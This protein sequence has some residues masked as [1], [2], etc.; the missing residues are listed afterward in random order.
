MNILFLTNYFGLHGSSIDLLTYTK[1]LKKMG[2]KVF[3]VGGDGYLR[4]A[5]EEIADNIYVLQ[6]PK[7]L[8][9]IKRVLLLKQLINAWN[10]DV[11][12]GVG[13]FLILESQIASLIF[14][15]RQPVNIMN[16]SPRYYHWDIHPGWH[17][18]MVGY[19]A[20]NCRFYKDRTIS[21]YK[22]P[23]EYIRLLSARYDIPENIRKLPNISNRKKVLFVRRLDFPKYKS[24]LNTLDQISKWDIWK[25]WSIEIAGGGSHEGLVR[26]EIEKIRSI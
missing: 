3:F 13:K 15:K 19:L 12:I 8:P 4:S 1:Y 16:F 26:D 22:W 11:I 17:L 2:H 5:F 6:N 9:S 23:E 7:Y 10:I 20:V 25:E 24:V 21:E 18:P 14:G